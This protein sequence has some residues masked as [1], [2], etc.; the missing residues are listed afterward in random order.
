MEA[1]STGGGKSNVLLQC[2][3]VSE[4]LFLTIILDALNYTAASLPLRRWWVIFGVSL[5]LCL[6]EEMNVCNRTVVNAHRPTSFRVCKASKEP[7]P[8]GPCC[9]KG[10]PKASRLEDSAKAA[11]CC[12]RGVMHLSSTR[13]LICRICSSLNTEMSST[14]LVLARQ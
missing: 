12:D 4:M 14:L 10:P 8:S 5:L 13:E 11:V 9:Q 1:R 7:G 2:A 3:L 6:H